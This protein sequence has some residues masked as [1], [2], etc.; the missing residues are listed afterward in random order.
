MHH[1]AFFKSGFQNG[2]PMPVVLERVERM[3]DPKPT[4][5]AY[6]FSAC[7]EQPDVPVVQTFIILVG[8]HIK[9]ST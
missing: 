1:D 6:N 8:F 3:T 5:G 7:L 9:C 2:I 4:C